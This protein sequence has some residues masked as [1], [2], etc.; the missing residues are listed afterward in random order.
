MRVWIRTNFHAWRFGMSNLFMGKRYRD[1]IE[2]D[3]EKAPEIPQ[4]NVT[5][6]QSKAFRDWNE[7][8][9]KARY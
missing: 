7:G 9:R 1:Y 8:A 6:K 3:S 4:K 2:G 5:P